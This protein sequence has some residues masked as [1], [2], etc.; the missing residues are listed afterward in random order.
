MTIAVME[1]GACERGTARTETN[2]WHP[3]RIGMFIL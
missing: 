2:L 1:G 3:C